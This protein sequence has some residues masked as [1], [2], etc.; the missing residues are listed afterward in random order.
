MGDSNS[1][2][3]VN[4]Y[5]LSKRAPSTTRTILHRGAANSIFSKGRLVFSFF[6]FDLME[7]DNEEAFDLKRNIWL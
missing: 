5:T 1:R 6:L 2:D 4:V 7:N 3:A